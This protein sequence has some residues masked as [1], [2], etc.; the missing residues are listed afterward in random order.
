M[1]QGNGKL[2]PSQ[3]DSAMPG[4]GLPFEEEDTEIEVEEEEVEPTE[5]VEEEDGSVVL[6]FEDAIKEELL[7]EPDANLAEALEERVL[8]EISMEL[9]SQYKEDRESR[10]DWE[11]SYSEGLELLGLKYQEREEPFRGASG[12]T[13]PVIAEAVTQFQAQAYKELLPAS[14]PVRAEIVGANTPEIE[15]QSQRVQDFMNYQIMHVMEEYD[16][17]GS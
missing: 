13:H 11:N 3:V 17:P 14:G 9:V 12:V 5:I 6:N 7:S 1:A 2:P 15:A 4:A 10:Q 16:P 8:E